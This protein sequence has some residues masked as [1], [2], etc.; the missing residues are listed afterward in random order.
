MEFFFLNPEYGSYIPRS[1]GLV[2]CAVGCKALYAAFRAH[3][4]YCRL[5]D[6]SCPVLSSGFVYTC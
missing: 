6:K 1:V 3:C 5:N 2:F 4:F